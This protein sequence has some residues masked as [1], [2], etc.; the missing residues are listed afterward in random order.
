MIFY[1]IMNM[2]FEQGK[3]MMDVISFTC[4]LPDDGVDSIFLSPNESMRFILMDNM[5]N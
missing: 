1:P 2:D 3:F 5:P 4:N